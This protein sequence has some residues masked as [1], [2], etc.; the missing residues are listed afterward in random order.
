MIY[1]KAGEEIF[2]LSAGFPVISVLIRAI[3]VI[4]VSLF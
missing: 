3:S 2:V 4:C 1:R